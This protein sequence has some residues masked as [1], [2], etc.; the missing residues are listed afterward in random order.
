LAQP[1]AAG[2]LTRCEHALAVELLSGMF[3]CRWSDMFLESTQGW[4]RTNLLWSALFPALGGELYFSL[5]K[6]A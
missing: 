4:L 1:R 6:S 2:A 3:F 5:R